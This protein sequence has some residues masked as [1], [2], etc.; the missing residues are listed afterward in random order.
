[1]TVTLVLPFPPGV[2]NL[3]A[4]VGKRRVVSKRY[5]AWRT[6]AQYAVADRFDEKSDAVSGPFVARL[7]FDRPDKRRRDLDGLVKA[8]LD[9]LVSMGV[10][11]DDHL[12]Q[13]I[14]L[15]WSDKAPAKPGH[16]T[17]HLEAA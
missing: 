13:R 7:S 11:E 2:N 17:I 1:M 16:V 9:L 6:V 10:I 4:T 15:E 3:F 5:A 14:T 8:P 12:A